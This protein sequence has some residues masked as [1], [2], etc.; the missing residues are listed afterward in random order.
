MERQ[1]W[2][3]ENLPKEYPTKCGRKELNEAIQDLSDELYKETLKGRSNEFWRFLILNLIQLGHN[4]LQRRNNSLVA[5][6]TLGGVIISLIALYISIKSAQT[7]SNWELSQ[8]RM[9]DEQKQI[10]KEILEEI[11]IRSQP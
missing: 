10:Q 11:K 9:L 4:E 6:T 3:T 7:S 2:T 5:K 8:M 1:K